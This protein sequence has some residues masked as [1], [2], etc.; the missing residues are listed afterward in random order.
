[1]WRDP[2]E[3][4]QYSVMAADEIRVDTNAARGELFTRGRLLD[5][6]GQLL[7]NFGQTFRVWRGS[8]VLQLEIELEPLVEPTSDAWNS[9]F[10]CR[11]AWADDSASLFAGVNQTRQPVHKQR[12]E[13]PLYFDV[14]SDA[15]RTTILTGGLPFHRRVG[16]RMLD[17]LLVVRGEQ[18]RLFRLGIGIDLPQSL[19]EAISLLAPPTQLEQPAPAPIPPQS[20]F[21]HLDTRS[22]IPTHWSLIS[23]GARICGVRVRLLESSGRSGRVK[24]AAFRPFVGARQVNF[25]GESLSEC[26]VTDGRIG[27]DISAH[28]WIEVEGR[29]S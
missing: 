18:E 12:L 11:F 19:P 1:V 25:V 3:T 4:A 8:R 22:V 16:S 26:P 6:E 21:F 10:A 17:S 14:D 28:E 5:R 27:I 29:W 23:D 7:A 13:A 9:Y 2:D 24:L 20:W 15:A